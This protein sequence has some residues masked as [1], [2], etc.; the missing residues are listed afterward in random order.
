VIQRDR[1]VSPEFLFIHRKDP[2]L[3]NLHRD[4]LLTQASCIS[5]S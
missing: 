3:G 4:P 2:N 5:G 1:Y